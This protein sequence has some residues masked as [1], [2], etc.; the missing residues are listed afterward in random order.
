MGHRGWFINAASLPRAA[1]ESESLGHFLARILLSGGRSGRLAW[2][3]GRDLRSHQTRNQENSQ[4]QQQVE[5][6]LRTHHR[7]SPCAKIIATVARHVMKSRKTIT[8][9]RTR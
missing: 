3:G 4:Q 6:P 8:I 2:V 5:T 1:T 7:T 9:E